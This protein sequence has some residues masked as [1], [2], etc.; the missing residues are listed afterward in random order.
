M[1]SYE[2]MILW[3][4]QLKILLLFILIR[5]KLCDGIDFLY[6]I[7][8]LPV[9]SIQ[10][11]YL[12]NLNF[13]FKF[14]LCIMGEWLVI[15]CSHRWITSSEL[16]RLFVF[17]TAGHNDFFK[18]LVLSF[19]RSVCIWATNLLSMLFLNFLMWMLVILSR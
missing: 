15:R 4:T 6:T 1:T 3:L 9:L 18:F 2:I 12:P 7:L 14:Y 10:S 5:I 8:I 11:P 17:E 13:L 16:L 19:R